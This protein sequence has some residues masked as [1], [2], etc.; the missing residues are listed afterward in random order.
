MKAN[1]TIRCGKLVAALMSANLELIQHIKHHLAEKFGACDLTSQCFCFDD[2]SRYYAREMGGSLQKQ[3]VSFST[4]ISVEELPAIKLMTNHLE[5]EYAMGEQRRI[6]I[7]PGYVDFAQMVLATTK[8]YSHRV[9]L[10]KGIHAE[11]TYICRK[12]KLYP[13]EWTYPDYREPFALD[14]FEQVRQIYLKQIREQKRTEKP[15]EK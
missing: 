8:P 2:F 9:Y 10:G 6:N 11:L 1:D 3:F 7:D 15:P 14:F 5:E 13:L 12:R 4:L